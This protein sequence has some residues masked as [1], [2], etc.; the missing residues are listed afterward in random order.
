L[1]SPEKKWKIA[2]GALTLLITLET[3]WISISPLTAPTRIDPSEAQRFIV[4]FY[5]PAA[6]QDPAKSL[7][8]WGTAEFRAQKEATGI[9]K[10]IAYYR[11]TKAVDHISV[12]RHNDE[13]YLFEASFDRILKKGGIQKVRNVFGLECASRW[14]AHIPWEKC[15]AENLRLNY[16]AQI[17]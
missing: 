10:H 1:A 5:Y 2:A 11:K 14:Q 3:G 7:N 17:R 13:P 9:D 15:D 8:H 4:Q 12:V 16:S 6:L